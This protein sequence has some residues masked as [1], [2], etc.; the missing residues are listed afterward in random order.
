MYRGHSDTRAAQEQ[1]R[2]SD[3]Y[4]NAYKGLQESDHVDNKQKF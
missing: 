2:M 3:E 1:R 4:T